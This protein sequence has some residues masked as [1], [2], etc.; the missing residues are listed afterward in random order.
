MH[1]LN[2]LLI[3]DFQHLVRL[4][5]MLSSLAFVMCFSYYFCLSQWRTHYLFT[6]FLLFLIDLYIMD[7]LKYGKII[8]S[9]LGLIFKHLHVIAIIM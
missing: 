7:I 6:F 1:T 5:Q 4:L 2:A 3:R 8:F 9:Q